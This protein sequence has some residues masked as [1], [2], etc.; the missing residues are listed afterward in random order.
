MY[1]HKAVAKFTLYIYIYIQYNGMSCSLKNSDI[2]VD[3]D[4]QQVVVGHALSSPSPASRKDK[5]Y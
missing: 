4:W 5:Q 3:S 2:S 1:V